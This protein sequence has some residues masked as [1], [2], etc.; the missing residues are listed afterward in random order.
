MF[1]FSLLEIN[2]FDNC[3]E[4]EVMNISVSMVGELK[5]MKL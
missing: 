2:F 3:V 1:F 5:F 4:E